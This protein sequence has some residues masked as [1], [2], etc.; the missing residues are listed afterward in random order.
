M[1]QA[2]FRYRSPAEQLRDRLARID[3]HRRHVENELR[4]LERFLAEHPDLRIQ[5][6]ARE[7][8]RLRLVVN[9]AR[10]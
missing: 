8:P 10:R 5:S 3:A 6:T 1:N 4:G 9:N 7:R 2:R